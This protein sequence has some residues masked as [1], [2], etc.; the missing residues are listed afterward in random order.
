MDRP[1][2]LGANGLPYTID[3]FDLAGQI[4]S[5]K[6]QAA[7]DLEGDWGKGLLAQPTHHETQIPLDLTVI[8]F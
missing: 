4:S 6:F 7:P 5:E 1:S 8:N 3:Q 2:A